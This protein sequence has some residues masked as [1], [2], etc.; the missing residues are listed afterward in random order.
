MTGKHLPITLEKES[1]TFT[2]VTTQL[3]IQN[4]E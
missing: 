2:K 4:I 1:H 3:E